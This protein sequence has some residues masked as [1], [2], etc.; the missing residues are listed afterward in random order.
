[1]NETKAL[2][3]MESF[4]ERVKGKLRDDIGSLLPDE[5]VQQMVERVINEEFFVKR[6]VPKPD[7]GSYSNETI[8]ANSP[9]QEMVIN[10][11]RD[12]IE[13]HALLVVKKHV[14]DIEAQIE[15]TIQNGLI[16]LV[17]KSLDGLFAQAL[18]GHDWQIQSAVERILQNRGLVR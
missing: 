17:L 15:H 11:C 13:K 1:M 14:A 10:A 2:A 12:T 18:V 7:R 16:T 5:A 8:E 4:M 6:R 9:F 3:P